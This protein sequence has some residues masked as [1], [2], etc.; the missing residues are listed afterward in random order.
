[1][2]QGCTTSGEAGAQVH[3]TADGELRGGTAW[4]LVKYLTSPEVN[5]P[6]ET[7]VFVR[8]CYLYVEPLELVHLLRLRTEL[9]RPDQM[10]NAAWNHWAGNITKRYIHGLRIH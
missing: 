5:A 1:M 9:G 7:D 10:N 3:F 2:Q 6:D 8:T 4:E